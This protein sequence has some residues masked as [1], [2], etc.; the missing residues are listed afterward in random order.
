MP[1]YNV[2]SKSG[3][4]LYQLIDGRYQIIRKG[5]FSD[6]LLGHEY[7]LVKEYIADFL[8]CNEVKGIRFEPAIIYDKTSAQ[9]WHDYC[10]MLFDC[11]FNASMISMLDHAGLKAYCMDS[12]YLFVTPDLKVLLETTNF[13]LQFSQ[14]LNHFG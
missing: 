11:T 8:L 6:I 13:K 12:R 1:L 5:R 3:H 4:D 9:E 10:V 7:I 14:G 2:E